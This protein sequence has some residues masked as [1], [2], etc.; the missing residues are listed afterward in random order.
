M[1]SIKLKKMVALIAIFL[2]LLNTVSALNID[3][4]DIGDEEQGDN[5][6][7]D[8]QLALSYEESI[9]I[10]NGD[11]FIR[12]SKLSITGPSGFEEICLIENGQITECELD[13][14]LN[15]I[16]SFDENKIIYQFGWNTPNSVNVGT[17][18]VDMEVYLAET[19]DVPYSKC[20]ILT[21]R[22]MALYGF[23]HETLYDPFLDLNED[24]L[25]NLEDLVIF[26]SSQIYSANGELFGRFQGYFELVGEYAVYNSVL[27]LNGDRIINFSDLVLLAQELDSDELD[28][29]GDGI[30]DLSDI[31][32]LAQYFETGNLELDWN[33]DGIVDL[34]DVVL[35]SQDMQNDSTFDANGDG[36][37]DLTDVVIIAEIYSTPRISTEY[38][39]LLDLNGDGIVDL[40]DIILLS[41]NIRNPVNYID[42]NGDGEIDLT[43]IV[44][45]AGESENEEWC[46]IQLERI[47][48]LFE[49]Y[50]SETQSF[51]IDESDSSETDISEEDY[52][53]VQN[54]DSVDNTEE[55]YTPVQE[56]N[57][58]IED[59]WPI[60]FY[61]IAIIISLGGIIIL[62]K[63]I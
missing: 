47:D 31:I 41:Q 21:G 18:S 63:R 4:L 9:Q 6:Y 53:N 35:I 34:T 58:V 2:I 50:N 62:S 33:G 37:F 42:L 8:V 14:S 48:N 40:T 11:L 45:A 10:S 43:E 1:I 5:I 19:I 20:S 38:E 51:N 3:I 22:Y 24:N 57:F 30:E 59:L 36:I 61:I 23:N 7:F 29:N 55:T 44:I 56:L 49:I 46:A 54:Y 15:E 25:V 13:I 52:E 28:L 26:K 32:L 12:Y 27:D 17:Y 39:I 16:I 60:T